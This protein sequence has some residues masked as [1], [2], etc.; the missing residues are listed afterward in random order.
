MKRRINLVAIAAC[1][2]GALAA[3]TPTYAVVVGTRNIVAADNGGMI[4]SATSMADNAKWAVRNLIDGKRVRLVG[5]KVTLDSPE[6][7]GWSSK[8][9][10]L[11]Q[12]IVFAFKD[13]QPRLIGKIV[14]DPV[15]ADPEWQFRW[16][17]NFE[18]RVSNT[19]PDGTYELIDSYELANKYLPHGQSFEFAHPVEA[20]YIKLVIT[21]NQGS[22]KFTE[23]GE[24]EVYEAIVGAD[25]LEELVIAGE[26]WLTRLRRFR[27][28]REFVARHPDP[29]GGQLA[30]NVAAAANGAVVVSATS[31]A[32]DAKWAKGN[33]IDGLH[34]RFVDNVAKVPDESWGWCSTDASFPQEIVIQLAGD[35]PVLID[36]IVVDPAT[37]DSYIIGRAAKGFELF[38]SIGAPSGSWHLAGRFSLMNR[39]SPQAFAFTATEARWVMIR[40]MSNHG[41]DKFVEMGEVEIYE[42]M[43]PQE[44][45]TQIVSQ[46]ENVI[47][48]LK[49]YREELR[50]AETRQ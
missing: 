3:A 2:V 24:F 35:G 46:G 5:N 37:A 45:L 13:E 33:L 4:L 20:R 29:A 41:S 49:Q 7:F 34:V 8:D 14:V 30:R 48:E 25:E 9:T 17:K 21:S 22:N 47:R 19:T 18:I 15:S 43:I 23:L 6:S 28:G 42:A 36:S 1:V 44:P 11:P 32:P 12:E 50:A 16:A 39:P 40:L 27:D 10:T 26:D 38:T 31:E